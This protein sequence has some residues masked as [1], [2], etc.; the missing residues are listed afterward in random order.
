M[1][2]TYRGRQGFTP[3]QNYWQNENCVHF[4]LCDFWYE[5]E[6]NNYRTEL[7][8]EFSEYNLVLIYS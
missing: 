5:T 7:Q 1:R 8:K 2:I 4:K 3:I 6:N